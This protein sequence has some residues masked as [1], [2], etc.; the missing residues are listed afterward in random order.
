MI[1]PK[2]DIAEWL[3]ELKPYQRQIITQLID[4]YGE[5]EA[6]DKWLLANGPSATVKFGG[7]GIQ[8]SFKD[9]FKG[10]VNKFICGH[11][12]YKKERDELG[13]HGEVTKTALVSAIASAVGSQIGVAATVLVPIV[14]LMLYTIGK[15]GINAY[16][17]NVSIEISQ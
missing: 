1:I 14:V 7:D 9:S 12:D 13:Q 6:I 15:M 16:C 11:P 8:Q 10:E 3:E 2:Y 4:L 17:T 5:E